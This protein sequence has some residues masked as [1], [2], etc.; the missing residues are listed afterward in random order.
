MFWRE[1]EN[2]LF[3]IKQNVQTLKITKTRFDKASLKSKSYVYTAHGN[4]PFIAF[5]SS[6]FQALGGQAGKQKKND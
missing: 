3:C 1:L 2:G 6:L 5:I 4:A